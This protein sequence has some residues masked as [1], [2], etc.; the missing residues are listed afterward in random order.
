MEAS[1]DYL[2]FFRSIA[3]SLVRVWQCLQKRAAR[4][5]TTD[6]QIAEKIW[7]AITVFMRQRNGEWV[8]RVVRDTPLTMEHVDLMCSSL[9]EA[10]ALEW[11]DS[12]ALESVRDVLRTAQA[13]YRNIDKR[14]FV[15]KVE[16]TYG[17]PVIHGPLIPHVI[18][19]EHTVQ[20]AMLAEYPPFL[21]RHTRAV[22]MRAGVYQGQ[23][24]GTSYRPHTFSRQDM[25][26]KITYA[27]V[28]QIH[29]I[30]LEPP[31]P[32]PALPPDPAVIEVTGPS[33]SPSGPGSWTP[34]GPARASLP[35]LLHQLLHA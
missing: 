15:Q 11:S 19:A 24:W 20:E 2:R 3:A 26:S 33:G 8:L 30:F 10:A 9:I 28:V 18:N 5:G 31:G 13:R 1:E 35:A 21:R 16:I 34:A 14:I 7:D 23:L 27:D 32:A 6:A 22:I 12:E 29:V 17:L 4:E 25:Y